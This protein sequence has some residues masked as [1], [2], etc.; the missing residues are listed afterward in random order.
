MT[1]LSFTQFLSLPRC[2]SNW[3]NFQRLN[4]VQLQDFRLQNKWGLAAISRKKI[5]E[6]LPDEEPSENGVVGK[7]RQLGLKKVADTLEE[8]TELVGTNDAN[9]EESVVSED[10]KKTRR[11]TRRKDVSVSTSLEEEATEK[12]RRRRTRKMDEDVETRDSESETSDQEQFEFVAN[13]E[14]ESDG[15][16]ELDKA[17]GEDITYTY[18][19]PPLVC[20]F[21]AAQHAF[22]PTGRPANRLLNYEIHD[23]MMEAYWEPEKFMRAP[24]GSAG[25]VAIALA[26]LGGKVA[27]M[28]KLGDDEFGQAMLY[29]M[30]VN[31]VQTRSVRMD[32]KRATALAQMKIAKRGRLRMTCSRPCAE[33]S[34]LKSELNMDVLKQAKMFYFNTHS[35]LDRS[36]RSTALRAIKVSKKLGAVVFYDVNLPLPLW[37]SSEETKLFIQEAWNLADIVEV[38]KQ[39]LEFL[40][41]IEPTEEFDSRNNARSKFVHYEP[42]VVAPLWHENLEVLFVTNGTS[43]IH[44]YTREH[45]GAVHGMEDPPITPFTSD[46]SASGDGIVAGLMRMLSVQTDLITNKEYLE[47]TSK[48]AIDCGVI[49][50]WLLGRTCGFPPR[51]E[52]ED[53]VEPDENGIRSLTET[54]YRTLPNDSDPEGY[55]PVPEMECRPVKPV[56]DDTI[57]KTEKEYAYKASWM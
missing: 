11:R 43:K 55:M 50:Q 31:N 29:Y 18:D 51:E 35:L 24:G 30:N 23:R 49:N 33:D 40:C 22:V 26:S 57:S 34:L 44:Y 8:N 36:M 53:E 47:S 32:S 38:T 48:Y 6:A 14:D 9:N 45:N 25:G 28:G 12:V 1:S 19:W 20:C 54:E 5:S 15:D 41:G 39:E 52:M 37:R 21:G 7:R 3:P 17:D 10:S 4:F 27:F 46:M 13:L 2:Q 56:P 42:E 16:L